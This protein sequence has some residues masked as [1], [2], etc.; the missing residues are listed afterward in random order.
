[1]KE[2]EYLYQRQWDGCWWTIGTG[3]TPEKAK[4]AAAHKNVPSGPS[5]MVRSTTT[6]FC[7]VLENES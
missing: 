2:V 1:M 6:T 4:K 7:E 5:R 3:D